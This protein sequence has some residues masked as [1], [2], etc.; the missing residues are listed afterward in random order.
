MS[1]LCVM[2]AV[3]GAKICQ[4]LNRSQSKSNSLPLFLVIKA[5]KTIR[6]TKTKDASAKYCII[7]S[8]MEEG[9]VRT[10]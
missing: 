8:V 6:E 10:I 9:H 5:V 1:A 4:L 2:R 3:C 7:Y